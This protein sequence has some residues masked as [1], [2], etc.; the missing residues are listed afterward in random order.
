[1]MLWLLLQASVAGPPLPAPRPAAPA[2]L[3]DAAGG[4]VTVCGSRGQ[5][6]QFRLRALPQRYDPDVAA[7][8]KAETSILG[9]K[10]KV[11]AETEA[12]GV[13][14]FQSNRGMVRLKIPLGK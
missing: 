1:M 6:E 10:A 13:G 9:G 3:P 8:P 14:G 7:L 5:Q 12:A 4:E 2:C 11:A